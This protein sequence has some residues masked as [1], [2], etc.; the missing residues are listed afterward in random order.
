MKASV[1]L[2]RKQLPE[3]IIIAVP[4]ASPSAVDLLKGMADE[5]IVLEVPDD[6]M[7]V[8]QFYSQFDQVSDE[9]VVQLMQK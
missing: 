7:G 9:D 3:K 6:F 2:L 8:G 5:M 4:V 1:E